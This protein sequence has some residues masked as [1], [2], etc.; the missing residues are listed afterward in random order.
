[1]FHFQFVFA[2]ISILFLDCSPANVRHFPSE[3]A[4]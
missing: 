2:L 1:L 3:Q 4:A